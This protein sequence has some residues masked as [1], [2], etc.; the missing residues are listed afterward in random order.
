VDGAYV[1]ASCG[2]GKGPHGAS[3]GGA[4]AAAAKLTTAQ[5]GNRTVLIKPALSIGQLREGPKS[6]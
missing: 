3:T 6:A 5:L 4:A 2:F 1:S